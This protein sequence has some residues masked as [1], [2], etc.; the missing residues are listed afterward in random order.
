MNALPEGL[1]IR[2]A[3]KTDYDQIWEIIREAISRG[4]T[5]AFTPDASREEMLAFWCASYAHTYVAVMDEKTVGTFFIK[6]N[7][8]GLGAHIANAGYITPVLAGGKGI[9]EAMCRFSLDEAR[10]LGYQAMQF[11]LVVK[12]NTRAVKLWLRMGFEII[13]EIPEAFNDINR[14][15]TNAY[16]MYQKF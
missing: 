16:I 8:P 14:G 9:G 13:G 12:S 7:Q 2:K 4:S 15:L 10:R 6:A 3:D 1:T 11:N 5:L